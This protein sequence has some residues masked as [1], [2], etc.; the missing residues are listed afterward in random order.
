MN[1]VLK[2]IGLV[3]G[4]VITGPVVCGALFG[5]FFLYAYVGAWFGLDDKGV[6]IFSL[7]SLLVSM[8]VLCVGGMCSCDDNENTSN[9][10]SA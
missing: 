1:S 8:L 9:N 3:L 5:L 2:V 6:E 7:G 10:Q 4:A